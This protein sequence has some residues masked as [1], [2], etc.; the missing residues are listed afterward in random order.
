MTALKCWIGLAVSLVAASG[1]C[2]KAPQAPGADAAKPAG[3]WTATK[4][5]IESG[6]QTPES[7]LVNADTG[8]AYVSNIL[9]TTGGPWADDGN[10]FISLLLPTGEI[11]K[12]KWR[13]STP[14]TPMS[15]PKGMCLL[16]GTLYAA[17]VTHVDCFARDGTYKRI[18]PPGAKMLNDMVTDGRSAYVSDTGTGKIWRLA[19]TPT[20]IV[21]VPSANGITFHGGKMLAVS[22]GDHD[23]YEVDPNGAAPPKPFGLAGHF[24][25]LDGIEVIDDGTVLVSDFTGNKVCA[26]AA[27]RRTVTTLIEIQTPADIGLDHQRLKLFVPM[28]EANKVAVYRLEHK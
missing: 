26:V 21:E 18:D 22:W 7:V 24:K 15:S 9:L 28:F 17:D 1:G 19:D 6:F 5:G 27:D 25:S 11:D 23:I 13:V 3:G 8:A 20:A 10:A 16:K 4:I 12:L 14:T 2:S